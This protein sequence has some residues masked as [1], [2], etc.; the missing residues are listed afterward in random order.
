MRNADLLWYQF[1]KLLTQSK[2]TV[3]RSEKGKTLAELHKGL[4]GKFPTTLYGKNKCPVTCR[5]P[6][7]IARVDFIDFVRAVRQDCIT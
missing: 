4:V 5:T 6:A 3:D 1:M 7:V 2:S